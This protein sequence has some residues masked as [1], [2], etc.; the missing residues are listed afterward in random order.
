[1]IS[2]ELIKKVRKL[3]IMTRRRV[4]RQLAGAYHSVFKGRGMDFDEVRRY[5]AGDDPRLIDWNVSARMND[6]FVK[7]FR[8]ERELSVMLLVDASASLGF[9]T[10][11]QR[12][13]MTAAELGAILAISAITNNDRV[14]LVMFTDKVELYVPPKRGRK[15]VLRVITQILSY[16]GNATTTNLSE[17]LEF[18]S[19]VAR[20]RAIVF[21]ISDFLDEGFEHA[22]NVTAK[23]HDLVPIV[24][25]D[26]MEEKL[27]NIGLA[28][29]QDPETGELLI[30]DTSSRKVREH[31]E[32]NEARERAKRERA[33]RRLKMDYVKIQT[34]ESYIEPLA[35]FF[36]MRAKRY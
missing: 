33:F 32:A 17:P 10:A 19:K 14:G 25:S 24:L 20:R 35:A 7:Q 21:L 30:I 29:F 22:L 27:P 15:H 13:Q 26:P 2:K 34:N 9:G 4:N 5:H 23:R 11:G 12:K 28:T 8:E 16:Q 31:F 18:V 1:M 3:E 36:R 6:L